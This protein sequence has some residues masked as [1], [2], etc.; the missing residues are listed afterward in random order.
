MSL[1]L[2]Q[3]YND[4]K[5][6]KAYLR[7]MEG[8]TQRTIAA[9]LKIPARTIAHWSKADGWEEE[10]KARKLAGESPNVAAVAAEPLQEAST[11]ATNAESPGEP[12]GATGES[13]TVRMERMLERQ[14]RMAGRLV[15][16]LERDIDQTFA[17]AEAVGKTP[18][19]AQI[20]Q[21]TSLSNNLLALERKAWQV[22]DKI[23]TKDTTP[24]RPDPVR[25]LT[26]EQLERELEAAR[27]ERAA[28]M[29]R[30]ETQGGVN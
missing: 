22:P 16:A 28:A 29:A 2:L 9:K 6:Q 30:E 19:R 26:D 12:Q 18:T 24:Q 11:A 15:V 13:R 4:P 14:Q 25:E 1:P 10:R 27:R 3:S 8:G 17:A 21:L 5:K 20:A 23:E 7:Y